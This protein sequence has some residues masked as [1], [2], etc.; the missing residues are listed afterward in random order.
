MPHFTSLQVDA[1]ALLT[2]NAWD[3]S[4]GGLLFVRVQGAAKVLGDL[5]MDGKG[6]RGGAGG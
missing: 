5:S 4:K 6:F 2:A 1:G 3:G